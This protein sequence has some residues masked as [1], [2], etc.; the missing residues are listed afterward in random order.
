MIDPNQRQVEQ[1]NRSQAH[2][3]M[4][5]N[6]LFKPLDLGAVLLRSMSDCKRGSDVSENRKERL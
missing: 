2:Q 5:C 3:M 4:S 6:K 1:E